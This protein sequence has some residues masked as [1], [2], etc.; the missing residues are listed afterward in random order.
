MAQITAGI[1]VYWGIAGEN[2]AKPTDWTKIQ[3]ITSIPE[4]GGSPET[5]E[6]T[7]LDNL[8]YKTYANGLKDTGGALQLQ[9]NDTPEFRVAAKALLEAQKT[10]KIYYAIDIPAPIS[11]HMVFQGKANPLGFGGAE[12]NGVLTTS[13][14]VTPATEPE[15]VEGNIEENV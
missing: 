6:T 14:Y 11:E 13:L 10:N 1:G 8:E 5:I 3:G 12:V 9:A 2:D 7:S 4:I 15:W